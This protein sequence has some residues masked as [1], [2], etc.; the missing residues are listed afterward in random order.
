MRVPT[1]VSAAAFIAIVPGSIG[2]WIPWCIAT[3]G[4]PVVLRTPDRILGVALFVIGWTILLW[5]TVEFVRRGRGTPSPERAPTKLV[6]SGLF[7]IVRNPMY[8]GVVTAIMGIAIAMRSWETAL[9]GLVVA[10]AFHLR[11]LFYEEPR[12]TREFGDEFK[13]YC[14]R[15]PRW[16]PRVTPRAG[17]T[18][19]ATDSRL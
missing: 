16:I 8:V 2:G 15:V 17:G 12:L 19:S 18:K 9:Y 10:I 1:A 14:E 11:V 7:R 5:C 4:L 3:D 6:V 13:A